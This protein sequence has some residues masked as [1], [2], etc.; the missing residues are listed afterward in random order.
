MKK[1]T[2]RP[3]ILGA[4]KEYFYRHPNVKVNIYQLEDALG[5]DKRQ[6]QNSIANS[7]G[8]KP[9]LE[10]LE[11]GR[12]YRFTPY[13]EPVEELEEVEETEE[14]PVDDERGFY[15]VSTSVEGLPILQKDTDGTFWV[16]HPV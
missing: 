2:K 9:W 11:R 8:I 16:A 14:E 4:I 12:A 6:I 10:V 3:N 1:G 13:S 5:F 15:Q 7:N